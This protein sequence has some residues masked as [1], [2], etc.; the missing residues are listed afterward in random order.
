MYVC[1][2]IRILYVRTEL[3]TYLTMS[4]PTETEVACGHSEAAEANMQATAGTNLEPMT[5]DWRNI[6]PCVTLHER[7]DKR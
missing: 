7:L 5:S 1:T 4:V 2:H 3:H 6:P